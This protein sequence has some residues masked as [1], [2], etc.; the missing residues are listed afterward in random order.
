MRV[1][2]FLIRC[3][4]CWRR[5]NLKSSQRKKNET[6]NPI[7]ITKTKKLPPDSC[8]SIIGSTCHY[9]IMHE[10]VQNCFE[11]FQILCKSIMFPF[12]PFFPFVCI[13][14]S[15]L[16]FR[17]VRHGVKQQM[18]CLCPNNCCVYVPKCFLLHIASDG[19]SKSAVRQLA[20]Q[21]S[22]YSF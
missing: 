6:F 2:A 12:S 19:G 21:P 17:H 1:W 9:K 18:W 15:F 7:P 5:K 10:N 20:R 16:E 22:S 13:F 4:S 3:K 14:G 11:N 8:C